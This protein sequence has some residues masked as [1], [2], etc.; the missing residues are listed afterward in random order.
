MMKQKIDSLSAAL[1]ELGKL[2][3]FQ[4][5]SQVK[6]AAI[7]K[8]PGEAYL[9]IF[10]R[11]LYHSFKYHFPQVKKEDGTAYGYG[12]I[13]SKGLLDYAIQHNIPWV[14]FVLPDRKAYKCSS[15]LFQ[16]FAAMHDTHIPYMRDDPTVALPLDYFERITL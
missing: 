6:Q 12:Q 3:H 13:I 10:K 1:M 4:Y 15:R 7:V 11:E 16:K 2:F 8:A 14:I 5:M 9:V